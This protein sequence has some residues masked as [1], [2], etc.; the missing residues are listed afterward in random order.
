MK[1]KEKKKKKSNE[2]ERKGRE[3]KGVKEKERG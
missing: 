2:I 3:K 1:E